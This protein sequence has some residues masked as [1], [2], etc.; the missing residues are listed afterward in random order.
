V[1]P[2]DTNLAL[3]AA[4]RT[5][6]AL[7]FP[8]LLAVLTA[9]VLSASTEAACTVWVLLA[10]PL[11][12][13]VAA[14]TAREWRTRDLDWIGPRPTSA[15]VLVGSWWLG[16]WV[17][18]SSLTLFTV[19]IAAT[20]GS[21]PPVWIETAR[22]A[23]PGGL[24]LGEDSARIPVVLVSTDRPVRV[25]V[26]ARTAL[27]Q[28]SPGATGGTGGPGVPLLLSLRAAEGHRVS[29]AKVALSGRGWLELEVQ[30]V[31][32]EH[33]FEITRERAGP[34]L[35]IPADALRVLERHDSV[36]PGAWRSSLRLAM[37]LGAWQVVALGL[38]AWLSTATAAVG[39]WSVWLPLWSGSSRTVPG[40]EVWELL[41]SLGRGIALA[42]P[43]AT[44]A[45]VWWLLAG[46]CVLL[47]AKGLTPWKRGVA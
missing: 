13:W 26:R 39:T 44:Y 31:A 21:T 23:H 34:A 17:A 30:G 46:V 2:I 45:A 28:S 36:W 43:D 10:F 11:A 16:A 1:R 47:G 29:S 25:V 5:A 41:P 4:R 42:A 32:G 37:F 27:L 40:A 18:G 38:G 15:T 19:W 8:A 24:F 14:R 9:A 3:L 12:T 35:A 22:P 33:V 6:A 7:S 20:F